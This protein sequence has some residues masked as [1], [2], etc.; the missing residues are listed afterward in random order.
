MVVASELIPGVPSFIIV[1]NDSVLLHNDKPHILQAVAGVD[2]DIQFKVTSVDKH[3]TVR[4]KDTVVIID[5]VDDVLVDQTFK[6]TAAWPKGTLT[7]VRAIGL[8]A[9]TKSMLMLE[10]LDFLQK[11]PYKFEIYDSNIRS[12]QDD[13][14][15]DNIEE[16]FSE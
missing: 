5:E 1:Y 14:F 16:F 11:S 6:L 3:V 8:T 2:V 15:Y 4:N 10:E 12:V 9:T 7:E 13:Y